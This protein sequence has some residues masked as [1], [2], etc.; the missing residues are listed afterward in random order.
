MRPNYLRFVNPDVVAHSQLYDFW[1]EIKDEPYF[2]PFDNWLDF[3]D[4]TRNNNI[5]WFAVVHTRVVGMV[6]I[7]GFAE[8]W[9]EVVLGTVVVEDFRGLG[10]AS[11]LCNIAILQVKCFGEDGVIRL[12]VHPSNEI[13]KRLYTKLGFTCK[14][15]THGDELV[16]RKY[17]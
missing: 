1:S 8:H 7:R 14:A 17:L 12:H 13:A 16:M 6:M 3:Y 11:I 5:W 2:R 4:Q 15:E 10:I 9:K